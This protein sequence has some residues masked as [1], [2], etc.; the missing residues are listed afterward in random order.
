MSCVSATAQQ[1]GPAAPSS[2]PQTHG[3]SNASVTVSFRNPA[4]L[5]LPDSPKDILDVAAQ[6]NGLGGDNLKPWHLKATFETF[7]DQGKSLS[8]GTL[9]VFWAGPSKS[10]QIYTSPAFNQTVYVTDQGTYQTNSDEAPPY[11]ATM[12]IEQ[13]LRPLPRQDEIEDSV[14][15]KR[16]QKFGSN[17]LECVMLT[18]KVIRLGIAPL[19]LFPS[20][21]FSTEK[22][23]LRYETFGGGVQ[24]LFNKIVLFQG[25]YLAKAISISDNNLP[26]A[27][28]TVGE[29]GGLSPVNDADFN[30]D[31]QAA[32]GFDKPVEVASGVMAGNRVRT[33]QPAYPQSAK[34]R[35]ISGTVVLGAVIGRDGRIHH[36]RVVS[37][38]DMDLSL[39]ALFCVQQWVYKPYLLQG[40][41]VEVNT[42]IKVVYALSGR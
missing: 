15:E 28:I 19:G 36:L 6:A 40:Q 3:A 20:Y 32:K 10:R 12:M 14:P 5:P 42:Q 2:V 11:P 9:E 1:A 26:L 25:R 17:K 24:V 23:I 22:P 37:S 18:Q 38:P 4:D 31:S 34:L 13:L 39:A 29:L 33:V 35:G 16:E 21:C 30:P 7:G 27:N 8:K 41:P